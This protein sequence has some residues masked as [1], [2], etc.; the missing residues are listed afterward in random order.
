MHWTK[1]FMNIKGLGYILTFT[2]GHSIFELNSS[3]SQKL[4]GY[5]KPNIMWMLL[6]VVER[7]LLQMG[8]I[9]VINVIYKYKNR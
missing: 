2:K 4:L 3:F 1:W 8:F 9:M 7:K 6:G 5:L